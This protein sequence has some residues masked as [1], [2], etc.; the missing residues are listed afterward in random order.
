[1][2]RACRM[3]LL[4]TDM[5]QMAYP[6]E[7]VMGLAAQGRLLVHR[8][9]HDDG[10]QPAHSQQSLTAAVRHRGS[11]SSDRQSRGWFQHIMLLMWPNCSQLPVSGGS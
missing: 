9:L 5:R 2:G 7:G 1:M 4:C 11:T 8:M 3:L 6:H 10:Q